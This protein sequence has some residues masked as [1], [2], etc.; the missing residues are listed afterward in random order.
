MKTEKQQA[1]DLISELPESVSTETIVAELE[2]KILVLKRR[3]EAE[4]GNVISNDE[5]KRR[6][7]EWLDSS[8]TQTP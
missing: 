2:L 8:G 7:H 5:A 6:L 1:L 4:G 3:Q